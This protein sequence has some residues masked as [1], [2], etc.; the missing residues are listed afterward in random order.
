MRFHTTKTITRRQVCLCHFVKTARRES[1]TRL[2]GL[3]VAGFVIQLL[4]VGS[5][6]PSFLEV[7]MRSSF[8]FAVPSVVFT[9][10]TV[11]LCSMSGTALSQP[12]PTSSLPPVSVEA[13][14]ARPAVVPRQ[15]QTSVTSHHRASGSSTA[16]NPAF[17]PNTVLGRLAK[18]ERSASSCNGGCETSYRVGNAPWVGCSQ[19]GPEI[20]IGNFSATCRDTL[21]YNTYAQCV[22]TKTFVG[23]TSRE[24]RWLCSSLQAG[25][26][27]PGEK[28]VAA[29]LGRQ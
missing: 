12:T 9:L 29:Q 26:K 10:S 11:L 3:L 27:L 28:Q 19:S 24:A 2:S 13:P 17:A 4:A 18:L 14:K 15:G 6:F 20:N 5:E 8:G 22:E 23:A 7:S 1:V 16:Q 21:S 25:G